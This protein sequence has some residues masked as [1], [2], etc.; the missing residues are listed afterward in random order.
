MPPMYEITLHHSGVMDLSGEEPV[1]VGGTSETVYMDKDDFCYYQ[2][3]HVLGIGFVRYKLVHG[4]WYLE[5]NKSMGDGLHQIRND[6][7]V[8]NGLLAATG[9]GSAL[10]LFMTGYCGPDY[11]ADNEDGVIGSA[12]EPEW[13]S[14]P[15][16]FVGQEFLHL[17]GDDLRITDDE[18]EDALCTM[19]VRRTRKRVAY[20]AYSSDEE[21]EEVFVSHSASARQ[22]I[23]GHDQASEHDL[24][25]GPQEQA[26]HQFPSSV[27]QQEQAEPYHQF[28]QDH[29]RR[30][31]SEEDGPE[32]IY[33]GA[34]MYNPACDHKHMQ[35]VL[36]M[37]FKSPTQFKHAVVKHAIYAEANLIWLRSG[38]NHCEAEC[39]DSIC[40]WR[41]YAAWY[42]GKKSFM[43]K[44]LGSVHTCPRSQSI[45]QATTS[46]IAY[47][48]LEQ[49]RIN[50]EWDVHQIVQE[51]RLRYEIEVSTRHCYRAK[52]KV[53]DMLNGSLKDEYRKLRSYV[54]ELKKG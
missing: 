13:D 37:K 46:W 28:E 24:G 21:V 40:S 32:D 38:K 48:F 41:I 47:D 53:E 11:G 26:S 34:P 45:N 51:V 52:K 54:A 36:G 18:F 33:D 19:G 14:P 50:R 35:F 27:A 3:K 6:S 20:L 9:N 31:V 5:P 43:V 42:R 29:V 10:T 15:E 4:I 17:L 7:D 25:I 2:L 30:N 49:F 39:Q 1:Y 22:A 12:I 23:V 8:T 16:N 44:G